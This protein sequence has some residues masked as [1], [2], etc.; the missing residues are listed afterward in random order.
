MCKL[1][2]V[3]DVD[4]ADA[5][6]VRSL[7]MV[8]R[9]TARW[10]VDGI[11]LCGETAMAAAEEGGHRS[12]AKARDD[13]DDDDDD[14]NDDDADNG[15]GSSSSSDV[16]SGTQ[17][18]CATIQR[19]PKKNNPG[20][21]AMVRATTGTATEMQ[22]SVSIRRAGRPLSRTKR[23][24][25]SAEKCAACRAAADARRDARLRFEPSLSSDPG[26]L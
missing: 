15:G 3:G 26:R 9:Q 7:R 25:C 6:A 22:N 14:D 21:Q 19:L 18:V 17:D 10:C 2:K 8:C 5:D 13:N 23:S 24:R 16:R 11:R 4:D 1:L 20:H 12:G